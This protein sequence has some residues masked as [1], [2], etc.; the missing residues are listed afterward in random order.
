VL[1]SGVIL[2]G[3]TPIFDNI[4]N[5]F[6][7]GTKTQALTIPENAVVIAGSRPI[8]SGP[9]KKQ[10]LHLYCPVIIKYKDAKTSAATALEDILR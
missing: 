8:R 1:G 2:N 5:K 4:N 7:T 10:D 3:S 9:G 6:I